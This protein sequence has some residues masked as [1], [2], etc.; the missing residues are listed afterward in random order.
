MSIVPHS[1]NPVTSLSSL[2]SAL[3]PLKA[4]LD[5][6]DGWEL[7]AREDERRR[8]SELPSKASRT[9]TSV[10]SSGSR[11]GVSS[12]N[13]ARPKIPRSLGRQLFITRCI[14]NVTIVTSTTATVFANNTLQLTLDSNYSNYIAVF[15]SFW[16]LRG[17]WSYRSTQAPGSLGALPNCF[18]AREYTAATPSTLSSIQG[19]ESVREKCLAPGQRISMT[20]N[21]RFAGSVSGQASG[22]VSAGWLN[23]AVASAVTWSGTAFAVTATPGGT[24]TIIGEIEM[25]TA[26]SNGD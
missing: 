19:Y 4:A 17:K 26:Y 1:S 14:I 16:I 6:R 21:P 2:M 10:R 23:C 5:E 7:L 25:I 22:A 3:Q 15:D 24:T 18:L 9:V 20:A 8:V 13:S 12:G 11:G